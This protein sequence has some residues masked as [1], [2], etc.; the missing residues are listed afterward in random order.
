MITFLTLFLNLVTGVHPVTVEVNDPVVAVELQLDGRTLGTVRGEPFTLVC[1][2][3]P[4]LVPHE[5]V[6]IGYDVEGNE[7]DRK[8][9]LVNLPRSRAVLDLRL[10]PGEGGEGRQAAI[11]WLSVDGKAP[12]GLE[13]TFDGE[14]LPLRNPRAIPLPSYDPEKPHVLAAELQIG[15]RSHRATLSLGSA[16]SDS[17]ESEFTALPVLLGEGPEPTLDELS[18]WL[19]KDGQPLGIVGLEKG[20]AE[21]VMV[22]DPASDTQDALRKVGKGMLRLRVGTAAGGG[23]RSQDR[24]RFLF[25][26]TLPNA[27][28]PQAKGLASELFP[29][30]PDLSQAPG[31]MLAPVAGRFMAD[32]P[33]L[34]QRAEEEP[35]LSDALATAG[36]AAAASG[37]PRAVLLLTG[38][39]PTDTSRYQAAEVRDYLRRLRVP[40]L[41]WSP[42]RKAED[43]PW[44]PALEVSSS[45]RLFRA[46][47]TLKDLLDRQAVV[48]IEGGHLPHQIELSPEAED[49]LQL[50]GV[51]D[52]PIEN[53]PDEAAPLGWLAEVEGDANPAPR[54]ETARSVS[55]TPLADF[56]D[57]VEVQVVNVDVVVT[58]RSGKPVTDLTAADFTVL[59]DGK[60]VEITHFVPPRPIALPSTVAEPTATAE[61][62]AP[63][64][65]PAAAPTEDLHLVI[66]V[67]QPTIPPLKRALF[68]EA[69]RDFLG[70]GLPEKT[71]LLLVSSSHVLDIQQTFTSDPQAIIA[72]LDD[73]MT[74]GSNVLGDDQ[75]QSEATNALTQVAKDLEAAEGALPGFD[76]EVAQLYAEGQQT[77]LIAEAQASIEAQNQQV[78]QKLR[79]MEH[80]VEGLGGIEGRK[81]LLYVGEGLSL[82][83]GASFLVGAELGLGLQDVSLARLTSQSRDSGLIYEFRKLV[84]RANANR[85]TFYTLTPPVR[86]V[87]TDVEVASAGPVS[88]RSNMQA[89]RLANIEG[90]VCM[91]SNTTGG[92]CQAGGTEPARLLETATTD[93]G[94]VY[95]LAYSPAHS[96]DGQAHRIEVE[97][98][99]PRLRVRH[100]EGY[101]DRS[102]EDR[103]RDRL[104]AALRFDAEDDALGLEIEMEGEEPLEDDLH[105]VRLQVLVPVARLAMVPAGDPG[106]RQ[107][108]LQLLLATTD[109]LSGDT[110]VQEVPVAFELA[111]ERLTGS[112]DLRYAHRVH[113]TL[114]KGPQRIALG[115]WDTLGRSGSFLGR[116]LEVGGAPSPPKD[117]SS[118]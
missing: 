64:A 31:G 78:R 54:V 52:M 81:L 117:R 113:L 102:P 23:I 6:A 110:T 66:F 18:R 67:D 100:R 39:E 5:L 65:A 29:L 4:R 98:N 87:V 2:F 9:Q 8:R 60:P 57:T 36:L 118:D 38:A 48:W 42:L 51:G 79:L 59:E 103:L 115:L 55:P 11:S 12:T 83:P 43:T 37:R 49:R 112:T 88:L 99:R 1:D 53:L 80:L 73:A 76:Q 93:L 108:R 28:E 91:L 46:M 68:S 95:S 24:L 92:R 45:N 3:G 97:V 109:P 58:D 89:A 101:V 35:R 61:S 72:R 105:L 25:P 94:A 33:D 71:R 116:E 14:S 20:P 56:D 22:Q 85:V 75:R 70:D 50:A 41:V 13:I 26:T 47:G 21:V 16:Y 86:D 40:L 7:V 74:G 27:D 62:P 106:Q 90:A 15:E 69:L 84:D 63:E 96:E 32:G 114:R 34:W 30:S 10:L 104:A 19:S 77:A 111:E 17:V 107:A 44:G 82:E